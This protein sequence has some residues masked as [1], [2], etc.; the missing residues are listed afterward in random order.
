MEKR[1][2]QKRNWPY[3]SQKKLFLFN[4]KEIDLQAQ[5]LWHDENIKHIDFFLNNLTKK[6][7]KICK[8]TRCVNTD[9]EYKD[10]V[11]IHMSKLGDDIIPPKFPADE[12][13]FGKLTL[14]PKDKI[15]FLFKVYGE[16]CEVIERF[17]CTLPEP[18]PKTKDGSIIVSI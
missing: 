10:Y 18:T 12:N 2:P 7:F 6:L 3:Q 8:I 13:H 11:L 4:D 1:I 5:F 16:R 9:F 17:N 15:T 14:R